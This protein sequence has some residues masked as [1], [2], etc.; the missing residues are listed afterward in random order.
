[1]E[2]LKE[3]HIN[4][5]FID[6]IK[7]IPE[8]TQYLKD[9]V[10]SKVKI[11]EVATVKLNARCSTILRNKLS[12]KEKNPGSFNLPYHIG[13]LF[14]RNALADLGANVSI[15]QF[16]M[17]NRIG[18]GKPKPTNMLIEMADRTMQVLKGIIENVLVKVD[19]FIFPIDLLSLRWFTILGYQLCYADMCLLLL[20]RK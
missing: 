17:F 15:M 13:D 12:P 7:K 14:I 19:R 10:S 3:F 2:S 11:E 1:M 4:I 16:S 6:S 8:Y 5:P 18:L 9:L 20:T